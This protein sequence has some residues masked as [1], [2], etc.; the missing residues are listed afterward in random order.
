MLRRR[1][2]LQ[3]L[4]VGGLGIAT[5]PYLSGCQP[6]TDA[7]TARMATP[8]SQGVAS[9]GLLDFF[10]AVEESGLEFH[11]IMI[12]RRG[13]TLLERV[14]GAV[15]ERIRTCA[16]FAQQELYVYRHRAAA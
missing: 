8:E 14:V 1:K 5:L 3:H 7:T 16:V 10:D 12:N 6:A 2:F 11:S 4:S 13:T 15:S 9:Q